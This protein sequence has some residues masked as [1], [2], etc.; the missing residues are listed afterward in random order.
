LKLSK[1][2]GSPVVAGALRHAYRFG[3]FNADAVVRIVHGKALTKAQH[4]RKPD[5]G[6]PILPSENVRKWLES[7]DVEKKDLSDYDKITSAFTD[8]EE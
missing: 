3:A 1:R 5:M 6:E 8:Q 2:H 4:Q 7:H